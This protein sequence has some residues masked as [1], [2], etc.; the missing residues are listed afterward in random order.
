MGDTRFAAIML[1]EIEM[2][3]FQK[4]KVGLS[5]ASL[6]ELNDLDQ[7]ASPILLTIENPNFLATF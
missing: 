5:Q 2:I 3:N 6:L 1:L 7:K 4:C